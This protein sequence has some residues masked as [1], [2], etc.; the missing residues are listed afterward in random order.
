[1]PVAPARTLLD[2]ATMVDHIQYSL[3]SEKD[4]ANV[5]LQKHLW[6][7]PDQTNH[8]LTASSSSVA[9]RALLAPSSRPASTR[10]P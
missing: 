6:I 5:I 8:P 10:R 7:I 2:H 3:R 4:D 9:P 1:L